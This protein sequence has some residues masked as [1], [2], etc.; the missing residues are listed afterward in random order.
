MHC[1]FVFS[2]V[3]MRN[4]YCYANVY[5]H[6]FLC[7]IQNS[8][9]FLFLCIWLKIAAVDITSNKQTGFPK[10]IIVYSTD[11]VFYLDRK[12]YGSKVHLLNLAVY[13]LGL[14]P[15]T[16]LILNLRPSQNISANGTSV[17]MV[18]VSFSEVDSFYSE[19]S[20]IL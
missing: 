1:T 13:L 3:P 4:S 6:L 15:L 2:D 18:P 17:I 9:C 14:L 10:H 7:H 20:S 16:Y 11:I 19:L 8:H 5:S 12:A